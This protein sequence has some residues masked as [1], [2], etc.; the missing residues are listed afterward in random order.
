MFAAPS[1]PPSDQSHEAGPG[2]AQPGADDAS[3]DAVRHALSTTQAKMH[4]IYEALPD[5]AGISRVSDGLYIEVNPAFCAMAGRT[6]EDILGR[7]SAELS[8]WATDLERSKLV[9]VLRRDGFADK[10]PMLAQRN[11]RTIPGVLSARPVNID[12]EDCLVFVFHDTTREKQ[13]HDE[14]VA[15]N[16]VLGQAGRMAR[17]G[18]WEDE[19]GKGLV[20]WSDVCYDI[21][22]LPRGAPLPQDYIEE[23]VAPQWRET[24]R[25]KIRRC[26]LERTEWSMDVEILRPDGSTIWGRAHGEPVVVDGRV[27]R[28]LGVMQDIDDFKRTE[29]RLLQSQALFSRL[30]QL[31]PYPMGLS[32]RET[33]CYIEVNPAWE[34]LFGYTR[35]EA[36]GQSVMELGILSAAARERMVQ[37]ARVTDLLQDY[38]I[39][40]TT[41]AGEPRTLLQSM[42][43]T[44]FNGQPCWLFALNDITDRK[45]DEEQV[46]EREALLSLTLSAASLG[47]WDWNLHT[48]MI[49]GDHCWMAMRG[50]HMTGGTPP[51][52]AWTESLGP[53][54]VLRMTTE[55]TRHIANPNTPFDATYCISRP[56]EKDRWIR[57][58]GKIVSFDESGQPQRMLGVSIDV[59]GQREQEMLLRRLAHFDTLTGLPN[60]V[61]LARKLAES[62]EQAQRSGSLLGVAYLD[63]DGFKPV[64]D[65]LG[66]DAG[67][68]L[69][70]VAAQRLTRAL[71]PTDCVARLGGD[72]FVILLPG[73]SSALDC[74]HALGQVMQ[75]I[76]SPYQL[77]S[78]RVSVTA[79]IGFTLYPQDDADA[80][81]LMRHADQAMYAAKQAGRNRFHEFD[82]T[83]ERQTRQL[84]EQIAQLREALARGQFELFLQ[85][86]VDMRLG[87]VVG[88]EALARWRH[89]E[90]GVL[91]P[92]AFMPQLEGTDFEVPFGAWVVGAGLALVRK[93]RQHQIDLPVSLNISAPHL[94]QPGFAD[95]MEQQ[96]AHHPDVPP[97]RLEIEITETAALY[98]IDHVASTLKALRTL[99]LGTSLDDFG[100]GYSSLTYLRRLPL[101]TLKIDQSFVHGMMGDAGD[102]AI[103]QGV[104]GLARSFGYRIIA[105]GVETADQGQMLLQMGCQLAQGYYFARPMPV[106]DFVGW[107]ANWQAPTGWPRQRQG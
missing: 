63:L 82:A 1:R 53:E 85:P 38:E 78:E 9:N 15:M 22:G 27:T 77:G 44:E 25:E 18:A 20:Y 29:Q 74:R 100:T 41:R 24:M 65:R 105:E 30:F 70:V 103:V 7:T 90:K 76:G 102:L 34:Q 4:A 68:R 73:L 6:R 37:A 54:D 104:I 89:P 79:S 57:S 17:L 95:W 83:Q 52:M 49:T 3:F 64:N 23:H 43:A 45:R 31:M 58:L 62:M 67:D 60:R 106:D 5:P 55:V 92:G 33:G 16:T 19:R 96:L 81:T 40:A 28:I 86:K 88:A 32:H 48:G 71:R 75:S 80:D 8:I 14:L 13:A 93:L 72:E 84:R 10:L 99:G 91:S 98:H 26:I 59:T 56:H 97:D 47:R 87:T 69:L 2:T 21:H 107:V 36:V 35:Q 12:G 46:R 61:L 51:T 94:Q 11:G 66:H 39:I 101:S 50:L 42:R